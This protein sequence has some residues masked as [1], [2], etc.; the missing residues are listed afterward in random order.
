MQDKLNEFIKQYNGVPNVGDTP[1]NMGQCVGL[2]EKYLDYLGLNTPHL[3]GNAKDLLANADKTKL[4]VI[5]NTP[6]GFPL[7]GD[8]MVFDE[9]WGA[10]FG[11]TGVVVKADVNSFDLFEQNNPAGSAPKILHHD[12]YVNA[13]NKGVIGWLHPKQQLSVP[14]EPMA[15]ITQAELDDI[16]KARNK[17]WDD[18]QLALA[19][20]KS[21]QETVVSLNSIIKDKNTSIAGL[22]GQVSTLTTQVSTCQSTENTLKDQA[23]KVPG[24]QEQI[25]Q[26]NFDLQSAR[27]NNATAQRVIAQLRSENAKPQGFLNKLKYLLS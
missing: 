25:N 23:I 4:D 9:T 6:T 19:D 7:P 24:L 26:L 8:I 18:L 11:H 27:D 22:Q 13:N 3:W 21:K 10:G 14:T 2:I 5:T 20:A 17:N 12:H 16:T 15:T 1:E